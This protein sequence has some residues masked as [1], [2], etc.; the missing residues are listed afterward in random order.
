MII[1]WSTEKFYKQHNNL[2]A[3]C[4]S[5]WGYNTSKS[6]RLQQTSCGVI[7][8]MRKPH[9]VHMS[10]IKKQR[11]KHRDVVQHHPDPLQHA[12]EV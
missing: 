9:T 12:R 6:S 5:V 10:A 2:K 11:E 4:K 1:S 8:S 7:D 3:H